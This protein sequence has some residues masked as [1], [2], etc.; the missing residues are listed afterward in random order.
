[1]D[2]RDR[3]LDSRGRL[4]VKFSWLVDP[5]PPSPSFSLSFFVPLCGPP[6]A[7]SGP[8]GP[9]R[10]PPVCSCPPTAS[11]SKSPGV[12]AAAVKVKTHHVPSPFVQ[13]CH[14]AGCDQ[15]T[16]FSS[17]INPPPP[18]PSPSIPRG[19]APPGGSV[20]SLSSHPISGRGPAPCLFSF[21]YPLFCILLLFC[22]I[23]PVALLFLITL[24][25]L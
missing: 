25:H 16:K 1:M 24:T 6:F 9:W 4:M 13:G 23:P 10:P 11:P 20:F 2:R 14:Y 15:A 21:Q 5:R 22:S 18:H 3:G 12:K 7:T 8:S 17:K 19:A